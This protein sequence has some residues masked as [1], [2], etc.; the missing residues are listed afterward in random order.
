MPQHVK[1]TRLVPRDRTLTL[2]HRAYIYIYINKDVVSVFVGACLLSDESNTLT[3]S[4]Y[5]SATKNNNRILD[6][7]DG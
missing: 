7:V 1:I 5:L 6:V 2:P 3:L 4:R